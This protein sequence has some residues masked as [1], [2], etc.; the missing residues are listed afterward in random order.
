[1]SFL[2]ILIK[3][4]L[5]F[6]FPQTKQILEL[7]K[8]SAEKLF[9]I[10]SPSYLNDQHTL[11]L[12]NYQDKLVKQIIWEVKYKGNRNLVKKLGI[13]L[14]DVITSELEERNIFEQYHKVLLLPIPISDQRRL[15]RG[16]N[17]VELIA[18][19][20]KSH[21]ITNRIQYLPRELTKI[22]HTESQTRT[23]NKRERLENLQN[24]MKILNPDSISGKFVL[25]ID[26]VTTTGATFKEAKRALAIA[27]ARKILCIALAH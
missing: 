21:D 19:A 15:K 26:D 23:T 14:Y 24:S 8:L 9:N 6:L 18:R 11:T 3:S 7:E 2:S 4:L 17:Q 10:L 1:M 16:W 22:R 12:F 5:E 13:I 27:K 25:L 20:I